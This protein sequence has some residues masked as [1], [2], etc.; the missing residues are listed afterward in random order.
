MSTILVVTRV[1]LCHLTLLDKERRLLF[2]GETVVQQGSTVGTLFVLEH[3]RVSIQAAKTTVFQR[4]VVTLDAQVLTFS[5]PPVC[6]TLLGR[7]DRTDVS[8]L[9]DLYG[10]PP[11]PYVTC[12]DFWCGNG[13]RSASG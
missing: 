11:S 10:H 13:E 4:S 9:S 1:I 12:T 5:F 2:A 8:H 3:G 6:F 7:I